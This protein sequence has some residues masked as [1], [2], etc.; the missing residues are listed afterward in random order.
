MAS[1]P[2]KK[3]SIVICEDQRLFRQLLSHYILHHPDFVVV[4]EASDG[5]YALEVCDRHKPDIVLLDLGLP[6]N[7]HGFDILKH[8]KKTHPECRVMII[9]ADDNPATLQ[10]AVRLGADGYVEK[11]APIETVCHA[12]YKVAEG[13][14]YFSPRVEELLNSTRKSGNR[15]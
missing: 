3:K 4:G 7:L 9:S 2:Q 13:E 10:K 14:P 1:S 5:Q 12:I 8:V 6:G 11:E 15:V